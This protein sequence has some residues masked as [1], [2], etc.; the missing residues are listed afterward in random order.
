MKNET[1]IIDK[2][3]F[4]IDANFNL[5]TSNKLPFKEKI[6]SFW[7]ANNTIVTNESCLLK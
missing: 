3:G 4:F 2:R 5:K 7:M 6:K 1:N